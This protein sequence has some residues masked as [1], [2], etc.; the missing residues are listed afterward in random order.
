MHVIKAF[1]VIA[2]VAW[3]AGLF[4]LPRLFVYHS[5]TT[6]TLGKT[7]FVIMEH[8]LYYFI[9]MPAALLTT[10]LGMVLAILTWP[11]VH[12]AAWF[13]VK[14]ALVGL[15]WWFQFACGR[16]LYQ[17]KQDKSPHGERFYRFMNE[18]PTLLL[19][20]IVLLVYLKP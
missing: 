18:I 16:W 13:Y 6:D 8:K 19:I 5:S 17:F 12:N 10:L 3:F 7:R 9:M 11:E 15:L 4:Y 1:H 14:I 2:M 20:A